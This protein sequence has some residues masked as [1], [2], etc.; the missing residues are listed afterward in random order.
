MDERLAEVLRDE[1]RNTGFADS[2]SFPTNEQEVLSVVAECRA[3]G[4]PIT[5]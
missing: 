2:V 3:H 4:W 1:S 5:V